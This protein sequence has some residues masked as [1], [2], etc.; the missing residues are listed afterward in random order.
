V[1]C[2]R[3]LQIW[4]NRV[5]AMLQESINLSNEGMGYL[6]EGNTESTTARFQEIRDLNMVLVQPLLCV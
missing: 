1:F 3:R 4:K 5:D 6:E 2:H